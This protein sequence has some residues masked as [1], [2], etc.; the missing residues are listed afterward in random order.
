MSAMNMYGKT[1]L[2]KLNKM[3]SSNVFY[4]KQK[5]FC[6]PRLKSEFFQDI[7]PQ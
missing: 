6:Q 7:L 4:G 5:F 1:A 2:K 3:C